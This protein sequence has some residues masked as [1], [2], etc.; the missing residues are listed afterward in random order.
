MITNKEVIISVSKTISKKILYVAV[1]IAMLAMMIPMAIPVSA[2]TF[3]GLTMTTANSAG[4]QVDDSVYDVIG[5]VVTVTASGPADNWTANTVGGG[6]ILPIA[7]GAT[8]AQFV[9]YSQTAASITARLISSGA[10]L[11][12]ITKKW[13]NGITT[14]F[15]QTNTSSY[16]TWNEG[17]K[18]WTGSTT[19][20]DTV[21]AQFSSVE[22]SG[23]PGPHVAQGMILNWYLI[24]GYQNVPMSPME[25]NPSPQDYTTGLTGMVG[26]LVPA[27]FAQITGGTTPPGTAYTRYTYIRTISGADGTSQITI[28][29]NGEESIKIVVIPEYPGDPQIATTPEVTTYNFKTR[30]MEVVPQVRWAGEKIVLEADFG[31]TSELASGYYVKWSLSNESPG[32]LTSVNGISAFNYTNTSMTV[33]APIN[34]VTGLSQV[35]L[36]CANQGQVDVVAT[37]YLASNGETQE[38]QQLF[39][40]Y[41][42]KLESITLSDVVGKRSLY[43]T[44]TGVLTSHKDGLFTPSNPWNPA[45]DWETANAAQADNDTINVSTDTLLRARVKGWFESGDPSWRTARYVSLTNSSI[46]QAANAPGSMLLPAGRWVLPDDW[47]LLSGTVNRIHWDISVDPSVHS[48][49]ALNDPLGPYTK[50]GVTV[51]AKPVIGPFSPGLEVMTDTGWAAA[52][53]S[54]DSLRMNKTVVPDGVINSWDAPMPPAKVAFEITDPLNVK[55]NGVMQGVGYF[56]D[57]WKTGIYYIGTGTGAGINTPTNYTNPFYFANI[58][59]HE[60]IPPT[61]A[62][63]GYDGDSV[64]INNPSDPMGAGPFWKSITE[65]D[66]TIT[67]QSHTLPTKVEV[68]SDNHCEAMVYLNGYSNLHREM[69]DGGADVPLNTTVGHTTVTAYADY[70]YYRSHPVFA[71]NSV[72]KTWFW[73]GQVL[74]VDGS[75]QMP[76]VL[77]AGHT[78]NPAA[79]DYI[80]LVTGSSYT[81]ANATGTSNKHVVWV[82]ATDRDGMQAGVLDAKVTWSLSG[83]GA[84]PIFYDGPAFTGINPNGSSPY[85]SFEALG[86][87]ANPAHPGT[88]D[89]GSQVTSGTSW[90]RAPTTTPVGYS[91]SDMFYKF[92][93]PTK[94]PDGLQP[95]NFA[96]SA[97]EIINQGSGAVNVMERIWSTEYASVPN[98]GVGSI[99]RA[100]NFM[101]STS[102]A[103]IYDYQ[104]DDASL[105]GDANLDGE[106]NMLDITAIERI[107]LGLDTNRHST[108]DANHNMTIDMGDVIRVEKTYLGLK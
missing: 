23:N 74:G 87:L 14:A 63:G 1:V 5:T 85:L 20:T 59:A 7:T 84:L 28:T 96:V 35:M 49:M 16:V 75:A 12:P 55:V 65:P 99:L 78:D 34:A 37:L 97:I 71:S 108:A 31:V 106:V 66:G 58:P 42:L 32:S 13:G 76:M 95:S 15:T 47:A 79:S 44:S 81:A 107:I 17:A 11:G 10:T 8:W 82:W 56:K 39:T 101:V 9:S 105:L 72:Q 77:T 86:F 52:I 2:T 24:D 22:P 29:T 98:T 38:N 46:D 6:Q 33:W 54:T 70:P 89:A 68:Y 36:E 92:Y 102:N 51:A 4:T 62:N 30:E 90:L 57:A 18:T 73:S 83:A 103:Y 53:T 41:Y 48:V 50:S 61:N 43:N 91:E 80:T 94:D 64:G 104:L 93:N 67:P 100:T 45:L 21:T 88:R 26:D 27:R 19:V 69:Y 3:N 40:V 25:A 60:L